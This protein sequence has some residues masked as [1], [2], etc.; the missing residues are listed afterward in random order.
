MALSP[1]AVIEAAMRIL[2]DFGLGDLTMRRLARELDV[3]PSALY[4]HVTD[5]QTLFVLLAQRMAREADRVNTATGASRIDALL[6]YRRVLL[7][8]R[9]SA[10]IVQLAHAHSG[11]SVLPAAL[12]E[13]PPEKAEMVTPFVLGSIAVQQS[14]ALFQ[15]LADPTE[16]ETTEGP[17]DD[18]EAPFRTGLTLLLAG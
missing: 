2:A 15:Q 11:A 5:K 18:A 16:P 14:R 17:D 6:R 10:D 9:E 3:Q 12:A 13:L 8:Y 1:T 7:R 4:W